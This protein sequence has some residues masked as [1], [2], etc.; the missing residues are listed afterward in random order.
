MSFWSKIKPK[1]SWLKHVWTGAKIANTVTKFIPIIGLPSQVI[2][3]LRGTIAVVEARG[4]KAKAKKAI[5]LALP[6]LKDLGLDKI[7]V[8]KLHLGVELLLDP[9]VAGD[10][11]YA[12]F[13]ERVEAKRKAGFTDEE[14][15][16]LRALDR[17]LG[18]E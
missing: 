15:E 7:P 11:D 5:L 3:I 12:D 4:G 13:M 2:D 9:D 14:I 16:I 1:K 17:M 6:L 18:G 10:F 8:K